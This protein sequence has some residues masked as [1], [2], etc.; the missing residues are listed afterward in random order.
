[1]LVSLDVPQKTHPDAAIARLMAATAQ[2]SADEFP[3]LAFGQPLWADGYYFAAP[4]RDLS[5]REIV[6]FLAFQR[7]A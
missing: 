2:R 4:P 3:D 6:R 7:Q 5:D 1:V